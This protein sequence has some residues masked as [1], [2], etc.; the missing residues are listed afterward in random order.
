MFTN[1][2]LKVPVIG[3]IE[4][5][6]WFT[7]V[8]HPDEIYYLFGRGSGLKLAKEF[9]SMLLGEVPLVM[10]VGEAAEKGLS[11]FSQGNKSVVTAFEKI[12]EL[13]IAKTE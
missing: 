8:Q 7:P 12:A 10:E 3:I 1:S 11:V 2:D 4:N 13:L 5:M 9:D 6:A